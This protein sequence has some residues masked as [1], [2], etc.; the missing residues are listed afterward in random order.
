[1]ESLSCQLPF[2][3]CTWMPFS[4]EID[5]TCMI[6]S[7][8]RPILDSSLT[9]KLSPSLSSSRILAIFLFFQETVP[10]AKNGQ[11]EPLKT[12]F[13]EPLKKSFQTMLCYKRVY[14]NYCYAHFNPAHLVYFDRL[15]QKTIRLIH[16]SFIYSE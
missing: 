5:N 7:I 8:L 11:S 4:M 3:A 16:A 2:T 12:E 13:F 9:I 6:S 14:N 15:I 10:D 1:M